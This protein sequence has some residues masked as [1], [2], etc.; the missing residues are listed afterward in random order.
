MIL[1]DHHTWPCGFTTT[2]PHKHWCLLCD[3]SSLTNSTEHRTLIESLR[4]TTQEAHAR[5]LD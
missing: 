2:Y 4:R 1:D 5:P 3:T